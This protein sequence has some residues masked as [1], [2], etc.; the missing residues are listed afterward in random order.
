MDLQDLQELYSDNLYKIFDRERFEQIA[1]HST[2][3]QDYSFINRVLIYLQNPD[4]L[5]ARSDEAWQIQGRIIN[6]DA[7]PISIL[8]A[9][10]NVHYIDTETG[11]YIDKS[12]LTPLEL[13]KAIELGMIT[14]EV[15]II[16][17]KSSNIYDINDTTEIEGQSNSIGINRRF[18]LSSLLK[19]AESIGLNVEKSENGLTSFDRGA[20]TLKIGSDSL[21]DKVIIIIEALIRNL[22][23]ST[24]D[25]LDFVDSDLE[26]V[27]WYTSYAV[28]TYYGIDTTLSL[29][30][31]TLSESDEQQDLI[32]TLL[33]VAEQ[34]M[35]EYIFNSPADG[36]IN[37]TH[38]SNNKAKRAAL[39]LSI[40]EANYQA[41]GGD[42]VST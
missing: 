38:I 22:I 33:E 1:N 42:S 11:E 35:Q 28:C 29:E 13:R 16:K 2:D 19:L 39:L 27:V 12:E 30:S 6:Q 21:E 37:I 18:K 26:L 25:T 32:V 24:H 10:Q 15:D 14:K 3:I 4:S 20:N 23:Y 36:N 34:F 17:L 7:K 40:L 8:E 41:C 5:N 31:T 9:V